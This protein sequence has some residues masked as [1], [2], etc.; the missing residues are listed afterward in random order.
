MARRPRRQHKPEFK[1]KVALA[2]LCTNKTVA[3]LAEEFELHTNL[4]RQWRDQLLSNASAAFPLPLAAD[5]DQKAL[6]AKIEA[7]T[8]ENDFLEHALANTGWLGA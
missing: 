6:Q 5:S 1:A 2:A 4:V 3:E 8:R 7:L